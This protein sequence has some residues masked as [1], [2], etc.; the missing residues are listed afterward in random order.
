V[1]TFVQL[2]ADHRANNQISKVG[3]TGRSL[4]ERLDLVTLAGQPGANMAEL[5]RR[6]GVSRKAGYKWLKRFGEVGFEGLVERSRRPKA[7]P[8]RTAAAVEAAALVLR[9]AN[10]VW[11]GRKIR[12]VL[13]RDV[14]A[15][16]TV[17]AASTITGILR[18]GGLLERE[19]PTPEPFKRFEAEAPNLLWQMDFKGHFALD[20][21]TDGKGERCFP[22][23]VLDD[24]S[25]YLLGAQACADECE[26]TVRERLTRVFERY[27][28]P[29]A[30]LTDNGNPPILKLGGQQNGPTRLTR[31]SVWLIRLGIKPLWSRPPSAEQGG[32]PQTMGKLERLH[33]TMKA[34]F[35]QGRRFSDFTAAQTGLD[36]WRRHY[37]HERPHEALG[38]AVPASRYRMSQRSMPAT[39]PEPEY[40]DDD[41]VGRVRRNGCL[42]CRPGNRKVDLQLSI[43]F[44]G[45][46]TAVRPSAEDGVYHVWFSRYRIAEVDFRTNPERPGVTHLFA[47]L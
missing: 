9:R 26:A 37:N 17:P 28:L 19:T 41:R 25:R 46:L 13:Q 11:G 43:A 8:R 23:T 20:G 30:M 18:R 32:H 29:D 45:Q 21:R 44:A 16:T 5:C 38:G 22:M 1:D 14:E 39:L 27:G 12:R 15:G 42:R 3:Q 31:L 33:R 6:F 2:P 7:S 10:P 35:L 4:S 24:H 36:R 40:L 47:H 34:E